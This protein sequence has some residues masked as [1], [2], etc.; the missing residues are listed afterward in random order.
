MSQLASIDFF[1]VP[2]TTFRVLFA[3]VVLSHHRRRIV[4]VNVTDHPTV[5]WTRQ[6]LREA[7]PDDHAPRY[8]L[9]DRDGAYGSDFGDVLK[10]FTIEEVV[11]APHSPW[12]NPFVERVIGTIRRE[13]S[14]H[15]IVW[16]ERSLR[17]TLRV[18][19]ALDKDAPEPRATQSPDTGPVS[20]R[21]HVG[22]LHHFYERRAA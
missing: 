9:R 12:Q 16:N 5:T 18:Y 13:C 15:L 2:T 20:E 4:H 19:L 10:R 8:L 1:I 7:L 21:A 6:Q 3:L 17:R 14:D 22:D 11:S